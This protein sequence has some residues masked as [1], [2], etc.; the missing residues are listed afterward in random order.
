M[1]HILP[2]GVVSILTDS[3]SVTT[4]LVLIFSAIVINWYW[5]NRKTES[6]NLKGRPLP[7][8]WGIPVFGN[9]FSFDQRNPHLSLM[10]L[11]KVYGNICKIRLG[12]KPVLVLNGRKA[13]Y[14][15]FAKQAVVF[16][17]RPNL[18]NFKAINRATSYGP[19]VSFT[20]YSEEWKDHRR[21]VE[22]TLHKFT[23][24]GQVSFLEKVTQREVEELIR[25][26]TVSKH[27]TTA[28]IPCLIRISLSNI[29]LW[30]M[31]KKRAAYNDK[32]YIEFM[33]F[34]DEFMKETGSGKLIDYL[35]WLRFL[36]FK[37][38]T[39]FL[40]ALKRF[41]QGTRGL[42]NEQHELYDQKSVKYLME[43]V[44]TTHQD[45]D[46]NDFKCMD[47]S[48]PQ[49]LQN[50]FELFGAGYTSTGTIMEWAMVYMALFPKDQSDIQR[51]IDGVLGRD[52]LPSM[53]DVDKLPLTQSCIL[54]VLRIRGDGPLTIP[55]STTKDTILDGYFVPKDMLVFLN[56]HSAHH[57]SEVWDKPDVFNPRRFLSQ[58]GTLDKEKENLLIAFGLGRR[59]CIG[60]SLGRL[61]LFIYFTTFLQKLRFT[62]R[63]DEEVNMGYEYGLNLRPVNFNVHI[64]SR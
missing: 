9:L 41:N 48:G 60:S 55:H 57:D 2:D 47:I 7:G 17:G 3:V 29:L 22:T 53:D 56:L 32:K 50:A 62:R 59:Q 51:E 52:R 35:P 12:S 13:I 36:P 34:F 11:A 23:T 37:P 18:F 38:S 58:D 43:E 25:Y 40:E 28:D 63:E 26:L 16:S 5:I 4:C 45:T 19:T 20:T 14:N 46:D 6:G 24:R 15:A 21:I 44:Q 64:E 39:V 8:P 61:T 54:E 10:K 31:F 49:A 1:N 33:S 42:I 27:E 30:F